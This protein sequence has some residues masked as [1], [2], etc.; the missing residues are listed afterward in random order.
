MLAI[1]CYITASKGISSRIKQIGI[2]VHKCRQK[3]QQQSLLAIRTTLDA[4]S[5]LVDALRRPVMHV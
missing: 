1:H 3:H 5:D 4:F 2:L